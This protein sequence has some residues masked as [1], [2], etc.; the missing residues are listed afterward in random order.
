MIPDLRLRTAAL[1]RLARDLNDPFKASGDMMH[2]ALFGPD[3]HS[4]CLLAGEGSQPQGA[5]LFSPVVSTSLGHACLYVSDLWVAQDARG[6]SLGRRLLAAAAAEG[7]RRWQAR[8]LFLN[9][10]SDS[11]QALDFYRH[12]GFQMNAKD[13]RASLTG[14]AFDALLAGRVDA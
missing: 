4:V 9:V 1:A 8:A 10:Y 7:A 12:L 2:D 11:A 6:R 3:A 5:V 14:T 13:N